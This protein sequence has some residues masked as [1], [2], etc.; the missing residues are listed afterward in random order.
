MHL[1]PLPGKFANIQNVLHLFIIGFCMLVTLFLFSSETGSDG[2]TQ[3]SSF[4]LR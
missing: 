1:L 3:Y 4:R 2:M